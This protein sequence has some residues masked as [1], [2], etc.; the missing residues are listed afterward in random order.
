MK[1][2]FLILVLLSI[3]FSSA[4]ASGISLGA[5]RVVY[6]TGSKQVSLSVSNGNRETAFMLQAWVENEQGKNSNEF[7]VT[8]PLFMIKPGQENI[9]RIMH[10]GKEIPTDKESVYWI[11]V[12]AIPPKPK[13]GQGQNTLQLAVLNKIKL[14]YRPGDLQVTPEKAFDSLKIEKR[15]ASVNIENPTPYHITMVNIKINNQPADSVMVKPFSSLDLRSSGTVSSFSYQ[16]INDYGALSN[17]KN[18]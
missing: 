18:N 14:F 12:K 17:V 8:P 3:F 4:W 5:T 11:N 13:E 2:K 9:L 6:T 15:A 7:I 16:T 1:M 10:T